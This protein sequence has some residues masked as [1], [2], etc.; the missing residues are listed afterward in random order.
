M[1]H[2]LG[3]GLPPYATGHI[4]KTDELPKCNPGSTFLLRWEEP[5]HT[6]CLIIVSRNVYEF[7][8]YNTYA[9]IYSKNERNNHKSNVKYYILQRSLFIKC[10]HTWFMTQNIVR[11]SHQSSLHCS[12]FWVE[13]HRKRYIR[14][15]QKS[16]NQHFPLVHNM[17][18]HLWEP[19]TWCKF[20]ILS[21]KYH[22]KVSNL[23]F[24]ELFK[25]FL[26]DVCIVSYRLLNLTKNK[27]QKKKPT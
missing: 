9:K 24:P 16:K 6:T 4:I 15:L 1:T 10:G 20:D 25:L 13:N 7:T 27:K 18:C 21:Y 5:S 3:V 23:L 8:I 12:S 19:A 11:F 22:L 14:L 17:W 26:Y 2:K